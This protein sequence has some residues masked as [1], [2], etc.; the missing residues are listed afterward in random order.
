[1]EQ[2]DGQ[3]RL[4]RGEKPEREARP[5]ETEQS[6]AL[7]RQLTEEKRRIGDFELS[8]DLGEDARAFLEASGHSYHRMMIELQGI[9][10]EV[11]VRDLRD[12]MSQA[13]VHR[14]E[15]KPV[16]QRDPEHRAKHLLSYELPETHVAVINKILSERRSG[17][18][19]RAGAPPAIEAPRRGGETR[20]ESLEK[21]REDWVNVR[22]AATAARDLEVAIDAINPEQTPFRHMLE[23]MRKRLEEHVVMN[24]VAAEFGSQL[25][26]QLRESERAGES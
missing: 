1:M 26:R 11:A 7:E 2:F 12:T 20:Q 15:P 19:G 17:S 23:N 21:T 16:A 5:A 14:R 25:T 24:E 3:S 22:R 18:S 8:G 13:L 10:P 6:V 9:S 4:P